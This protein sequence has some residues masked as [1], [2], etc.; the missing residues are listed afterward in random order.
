MFY[1]VRAYYIQKLSGMSTLVLG[2]DMRGFLPKDA[3]QLATYIGLNVNVNNVIK[4][5]G[6]N[7]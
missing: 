3:P 6:I 1:L 5:L 4:L 2:T 7:N